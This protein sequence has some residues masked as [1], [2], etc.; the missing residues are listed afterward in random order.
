MDTGVIC[1]TSLLDSDLF[2]DLPERTVETDR[3]TV[4]MRA[5]DS[6]FVLQRHASEEGYRAPHEINHHAHMLA[7]RNL[8]VEVLVSIQS[9]GTLTRSIPPGSFA[10]PHDFLNP[11]QT[12]TFYPDRRGHRA[13][14]F[15][16]PLRKQIREALKEKNIGFTEEAVYVQ[17]RGPRFESPA[18]GRMLTEY[19]D[20][21]GMTAAAELILAREQ[22][23]RYATL[24]SVDN[25]VN[26]IEGTS[27][28]Y[29]DFQE[30][31]EQHRSS[32]VYAVR[33]VV[34]KIT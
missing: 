29:E 3:G 11:W 16:D 34:E 31:V 28:D 17:T 10:I 22:G 6:Y 18:E 24:C 14:S 5:G 15:D 1:G 21:V 23:L 20:I 2:S 12:H 33:H 4:R 19:G 8:D 25:F 30:Q 13:V 32:V 9:A 27:V 26:G 7:F